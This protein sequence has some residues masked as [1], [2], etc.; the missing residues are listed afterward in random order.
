MFFY[1]F[2]QPLEKE[3]AISAINASTTS[4]YSGCR[5]ILNR[6]ANILHKKTES[7]FLYY[8]DSLQ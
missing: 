7:S 3:D 1:T 8:F 4:K 6:T 2:E 5:N